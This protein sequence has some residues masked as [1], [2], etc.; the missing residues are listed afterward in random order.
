[1]APYTLSGSNRWGMRF[2]VDQKLEDSLFAALTDQNPGGQKT[3]M[4]SELKPD[5]GSAK[6]GC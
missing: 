2:G 1:M 4:G 3:P 5:L 6:L